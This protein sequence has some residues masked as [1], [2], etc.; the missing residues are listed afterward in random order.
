MTKSSK[1][2]NEF[3]LLEKEFVSL[4]KENY[5]KTSEKILEAYKFAKDAHDGVKRASGEPYIVHPM[6]VAKILIENN[7]DYA[8]IIAGLLHDV[9]EDTDITLEDISEKFGETVASLVAGVTKISAITLRENNLTE[10][11]S[12]K[13]LL[14][15]MG[16]DVR[17]IFIKLADRLHNMRT[18]EFL[19]RERQIRMAKETKEIFIPIAERIGIRKIR[20]ELQNLVLH[21]LRPEEYEKIKNEYIKKFEVKKEKFEITQKKIEK[22]LADEKI[23]AEVS[24]WPEHVY[25]IFKK[26]SNKG[27][28]K[29]RGIYFFKII[30]PTE[31]DCYKAMGVLHKHFSPLPGQIK[32]HISSPKANGYRSLHSIVVETE[33]NVNIQFMFRTPEMD[34]VCEYG[35]SSLWNDKDSDIMFSESIE[36]YNTL[37]DIVLSENNRL[38]NTKDFIDAIKTDLD[39]DTTWVFTPKFKPICLK[40]NKPTAI[41]FAYAVHSKIGENAVSA[42]INGKHVSIGTELSSGDVVEILTSERKKAPSRNWLTVVRT[43]HARNQ[44]LDY[45]KKNFTEKNIEKGREILKVELEKTGHTL[46]D[47]LDSFDEMQKEFSF[48]SPKEAYASVGYGSVTVAQL[49]K[50]ALIKDE[51]KKCEEQSPVV[52]DSPAKYSSITFPKCCSAIPGDDIV[53]VLYKNGVAIHTRQCPNLKNSPATQLVEAHFKANLTEKFNVN[54]KILAKDS[55]GLGAKVLGLISDLKY[56]LTKTVVRR[57]SGSECEFE[58]SVDVK[59]IKELDGLIKNLKKLKEVKQV[60]RSYD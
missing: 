7:M 35:I 38:S 11:D 42:I 37:K 26:I 53:G 48:S 32:D 50:Y 1:Q 40:S 18:I 49:T 6:S 33:Q 34:K 17:V 29:I 60:I 19:K 59:D 13:Q 10:A 4:V 58:I 2:E 12:M 28:S 54:L 39:L 8:T 21:C 14:I 3:E 5:P 57:A 22:I 55:I 15:A 30:V 41:D 27:I 9:V 45:F 23:N 52:I 44:I 46:N 24:G 47:F 20:S 43:S 25:S 36:K 56:N 16:N 31:L 51:Q